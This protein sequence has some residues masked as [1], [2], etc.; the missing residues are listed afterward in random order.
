MKQCVSALRCPL[1]HKHMSL[2]GGSLLCRKGHCFDLSRTGYVN[3]AAA[4]DDT[5]PRALFESRRRVYESGFYSP[6]TEEIASVLASSLAP[7]DPSALIVDAG[8]GEGRFLCDIL[9]RFPARGIGFDI[10]REAVRLASRLSGDILWA[11]A[12][13]GDIPIGNG[14]AA[15]L[16]NILTP[17]NYA[18]FARVLQK[19]GLLIKV[20]PGP[21]Y[22]QELRA[23]AAGRLRREEHSAQATADYFRQHA[24]L[25]ESRRLAWS[26]PLI[27]AMA[28]DIARMTPMLSHVDLSSLPLDSLTEISME[29]EVLVGEFRGKR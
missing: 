15:A 8:C 7:A 22:L 16:L 14:Q 9:A 20:I 23:L 11:V 28:V 26:R 24:R 13:L 17:A 6:L 29:M 27:P 25:I 21:G 1:C 2:R 3:F 5:Y 19:G 18:E 10:S 12:D 4:R